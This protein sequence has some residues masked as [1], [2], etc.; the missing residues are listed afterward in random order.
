MSETDVM[1]FQDVEKQDMS[2]EEVK[3][4][5]SKSFGKAKKRISDKN[6]HCLAEKDFIDWEKRL[7]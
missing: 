7:Q 6:A 3:I 4:V 1:E 5:L 2:S